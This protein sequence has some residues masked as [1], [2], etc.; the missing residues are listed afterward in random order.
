MNVI[1]YGDEADD[2]PM[3]TEIL[4][5]MCDGSQYHPNVNRREVGYKGC[6]RIEQIR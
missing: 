5:E 4:E 1:D 2:D 3:S 6:D